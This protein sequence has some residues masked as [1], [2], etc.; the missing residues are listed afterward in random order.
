MTATSAI[1]EL[2]GVLSWLPRKYVDYRL[3]NPSEWPSLVGSSTCVEV[4]ILTLPRMVAG[5][6]RFAFRVK[7]SDDEVH[8]LTVFGFLRFSDWNKVYVGKVVR[9]LVKVGVWRDR[10][11]LGSPVLAYRRDW[12][13][14]APIY[15]GIPRRVSPDK[16]AEAVHHAF[17]SP[18]AVSDAILDIRQAW[19]GLS[20]TEIMAK[21]GLAGE[22]EQVLRAIHKPVSVD[23]GYWGLFAA[24]RLAVA[25]IRYRAETTS[26]QPFNKDAVLRIPE[27][28]LATRLAALPFKPT[29]GALSQMSAIREIVEGLARPEAMD[30]VLSADVGVG[31]TLCYMLPAVAAQTIGKRVAVLIP[32]GLLVDQVSNEFRAMC[33][34]VPVVSVTE[35]IKAKH[36]AWEENPILIGTTALVSVAR[37]AGWVPDFIVVDEQQKTSLEQRDSLRGPHTNLLECTATALPRTMALVTHGGKQLIQVA[38]RHAQQTIHTSIVGSEHR[39]AMMRKIKE[40][41]DTGGQVALIYPR[42]LGQSSG[43]VKSVEEAGLLWEARLPGQ[44]AILHGKMKGD[45]K[46]RVMAE[47]KAGAKRL[48]VSSSIIEIGVTIA[49]LK[50]LVIVHAERYGVS[51]L[52]QMRGRLVRHGGEGWCLLY[53]PKEVEPETLERLQLLEKTTDGF[54][55]SEL[56]MELR[57]FGD[58]TEDSTNQSGASRAL[59][60][61]LRLMPRDFELAKPIPELEHLS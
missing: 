16:V 5:Q 43:D 28:T 9:I 10:I 31:K 57:G 39:Q 2:A 8:E 25:Q 13:R 51:T 41:L 45:E 21:S 61:D 56:D 52:H 12:D 50:L 33:P 55:L 36:V 42:V 23:Q 6:S 15:K 20:E 30:A 58:L 11:Q 17:T 7:D 14:I 40:I 59:F 35:G 53:T 46:T 1:P 47:V 27:Q 38:K 3:T 24:R 18:D 19:D 34:G 32:N 4:T 37:T 49:E 29:D 54:E 44:V 60:R 22:L 48:L 26:Q